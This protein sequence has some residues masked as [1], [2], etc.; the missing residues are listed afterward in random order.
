[1]FLLSALQRFKRPPVNM[2][3]SDD[4]WKQLIRQGGAVVTLLLAQLQQTFL[5]HSIYTS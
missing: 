4:I 1:M 2:I 5:Q 3:Y